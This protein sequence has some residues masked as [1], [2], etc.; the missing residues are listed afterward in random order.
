MTPEHLHILRHSLGL[1]ENG[2]G[3]AY[4]NH[5]CAGADDEAKCRELVALGFM[6]DA[7]DVAT[8]KIWTLFMV[9]D[10]GKAEATRQLD[11]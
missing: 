3:K 2:K 1:K 8:S 5:F 10:A 11:I 9:T 4:R 6:V 7:S